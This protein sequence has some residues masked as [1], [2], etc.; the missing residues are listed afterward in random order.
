[1]TTS[2][3]EPCSA[4]SP[5]KGGCALHPTFHFGQRYGGPVLLGPAKVRPGSEHYSRLALVYDYASACLTWVRLHA[6]VGVPYHW[7]MSAHVER[8]KSIE[9]WCEIARVLV[10]NESA[11][12]EIEMMQYEYEIRELFPPH[13]LPEKRG[14]DRWWKK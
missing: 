10:R 8:N 7:T 3:Q 13:T 5:E 11:L 4:C 12:A 1:M 9:V 2:E 14:M 6:N